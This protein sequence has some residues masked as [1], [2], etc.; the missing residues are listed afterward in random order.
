M[1]NIDIQLTT[2]ILFVLI[3]FI[4]LLFYEFFIRYIVDFR[5]ESISRGKKIV[6]G[7]LSSLCIFNDVN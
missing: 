6:H 3:D 7:N 4:E 2:N 1:L 5:M